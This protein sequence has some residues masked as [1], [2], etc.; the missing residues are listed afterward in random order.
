MSHK[1][2]K[3]LPVTYVTWWSHNTN[4]HILMVAALIMAIILPT[5][6][7]ATYPATIVSWYDYGYA[8][9]KLSMP[10]SGNG[11]IADW[12]ATWPGH[13]DMYLS[14]AQCSYYGQGLIINCSS[15]GC[16]G[17]F[18]CRADLS[19]PDGSAP[20]YANGTCAGVNYQKSAG[21]NSGCA[22]KVGN[23]C[24]SATG[25]KYQKDVDFSNESIGLSFRRH[26]NS[27]QQL[28]NTNSIGYGWSHQLAPSLEILTGKIFIHQA[29]GRAEWLTLSNGLWQG[30][31]DSQL[32]LTQDSTGYSLTDQL[33][34]VER[35]DTAG[36]IVSRTE[37]NGRTTTYSYDSSQRLVTV[38]G[39]FGHSLQLA[40]DSANRISSVTYPDG[41]SSQ[42][43]YDSDGNLSKVTY[44]DGSFKLYHYESTAFP[45]ALTGITDENGDRYATWAYDS[46]GRAN[47]SKHAGDVEQVALSYNNDNSTDV[48]DSFNASRHYTF[49]TILNVQKLTAISQPAGAGSVAATHTQSYDANGNLASRTDFNGNLSCY[50]YDLSRNLETT[51]IEGLAPGASCPANLSTYVPAP[52]SIERKIS[53]Q[54]HANYHLPTQIDEAG[55]RTAFNYDAGGNLLSK[56]VTD[57]A[58]GQNRRWSYTYNNLGQV[59]SAD[60]PRTD[61]S[62]ITAYSYY[63]DTT[64]THHPGDLW[65]ITNALGHTTTFTA[66]DANGRLLSLTDPNGLVI[67]FAY[68]ARGRLTQKTVDGNTTAYTYDK[69]GN[70]TQTTSAA[71]VTHTFTYDAAH[72]LTDITDALGG[73]IHYTL[74]AMG[75]RTKE[76]ILDSSGAVVKTRSRVYDALN[77]LAQDIGAY[78]QTTRYEYDANGNLTQVTDANGHATQHQYDSLN[79]LIR[80][81]DALAGLTDYRYDGQDRLTQVT[82]ANNHD[83]VYSYNGLGDLM[84]LD[85]PNTGITQYG[86]DSAGNRIGKTDVAKVSVTYTYDA[87]NR[88]KSGDGGAQFYYDENG[89][90]GKLSRALRSG[91]SGNRTLKYDRAGRLTSITAKGLPHTYDNFIYYAYDADGKVE[92]ISHSG[93][94]EVLYGFDAAGQV[95]SVSLHDWDDGT[96]SWVYDITTPLA[97]HIT[98]LP[99]GPVK[100]LTY[101][102]G[103]QISRRYDLDYRETGRTVPGVMAATYGY[104]LN[105]NL[106]SVADEL[107]SSGRHRNFGYD[108]LDRLSS[109]T[110]VNTHAFSYDDVGNRLSSERNGAQTSYTY[111]LGSQKLLALTGA[112]QASYQYDANGDASQKGSRHFYQATD[113]LV[114]AIKDEAGG[115]LVSV[116]A[117]KYDAFG[118]RSMKLTNSGN[119][120]FDYDVLSGTL[121][122]ET[123]WGGTAFSH[124]YV[125]LEGEPLA[126]INYDVDSDPNQTPWPIHYYHNDRL[127]TPQ[128]TTDRTG[129]I[130]WAADFDP[131]GKATPTTAFITQ[132][133]RFPGQYY[134]EETGLHYNIARFYDPNLG[135]YLQ[136]DPI[137][138]AGGINT[139]AYVYNNPLRYTDPQG[140]V[141]VAAPLVI[142]AVQALVDAATVVLGGA[143]IADSLSSG[144]EGPSVPIDLPENIPDFDFDK[145]GQCP[146]DKNG[147]QWPWKGKPPQ[148]GDKGGYKNPNGPESL[149]PDLDHGGDIGPHW[150]FND[151]N[152]PGYRIGP[153][154][155]IWPK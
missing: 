49:Q 141:A 13:P 9:G 78:N 14:P 17:G 69:A 40:Y 83:T 149:H 129:N 102:N 116:Q 19:C 12:H 147:N 39:P 91:S 108:P 26:Y 138:L 68:D 10:P 128:K 92:K 18:T 32:R 139:Y 131:F 66:Y 118:Y 85:S 142:P 46:Q 84:Q 73:K 42:Y 87:L 134:D 4:H 29:D 148:G 2:N 34:V 44:Q 7:L 97:T 140:L 154:G 114:T 153:D 122:D 86:Y 130:S 61:V 3:V 112:Q 109:A 47:L 98:H 22:S 62:D 113:H 16:G 143:M 15:T 37:A 120:A 11:R 35:Y 58:T 33:G 59:L 55:R 125:Y 121:L 101:G 54:W 82:D 23:P 110:G 76:E 20:N 38:T 152:G 52:N 45:H 74:D 95:D 144:D 36:R 41:L 70:L 115:S 67:G 8:P 48:V 132:N 146:V 65:K 119:V 103:K 24:D 30:D 80:N 1:Q 96:V 100:S 117:N 126:R 145:P 133:L 106:D 25:N 60:G 155:T 137:G 88:I 104:D 123:K 79:R 21:E 127:G 43:Q 72:R 27:V 90:L 81:T 56:A 124:S 77:R 94:R 53:S 89:N 5:T 136:S 93:Y 63:S 31:A 28:R 105:G 57:T 50:V 107:S 111:D 64:A 99:F 135:R 6:G 51:R 75:N 151:R 150:D 71:G